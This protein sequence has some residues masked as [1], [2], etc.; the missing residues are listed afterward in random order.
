VKK[1]PDEKGTKKLPIRGQI[2]TTR[3]GG[4]KHT[5]R[6]FRCRLALLIL[7]VGLPCGRGSAEPS[8]FVGLNG[9]RPGWGQGFGPAAALP[10]GAEVGVM[11]DAGQKPGRRRYPSVLLLFRPKGDFMA[12]RKCDL[13]AVHEVGS[14]SG[15]IAMD[16]NLIA[17]L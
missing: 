14:I 10:R 17:S 3:P 5:R 4:R 12:I 1:H 16:R 11:L 2:G 8:T 6:V 7:N 9:A 15:Q 13:P